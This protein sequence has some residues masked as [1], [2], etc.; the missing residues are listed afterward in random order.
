LEE[1]I[2][3]DKTM[4]AAMRATAELLKPEN[5]CENGTIPVN[6]DANKAMKAMTS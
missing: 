6:K 5:A 1:A 2:A 4:M 3:L